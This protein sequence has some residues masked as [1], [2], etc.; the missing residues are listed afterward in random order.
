LAK[1][2]SVMPTTIVVMTNQ[3]RDI[4]RSAPAAMLSPRPKATIGTYVVIVFGTRT[5]K[6]I[7]TRHG[8]FVVG[9]PRLRRHRMVLKRTINP[10][11]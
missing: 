5:S 1:S 6:H 3:P 10:R 9:E 7:A 2:A 4:L 8:S 11:R